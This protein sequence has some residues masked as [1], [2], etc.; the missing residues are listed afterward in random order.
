MSDHYDEFREDYYA[1][2]RRQEKQRIAR[3]VADGRIRVPQKVKVAM[4][5]IIKAHTVDPEALRAL[6]DFILAARS[7]EATKE[8]T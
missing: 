7:T 5:S 8:R 3:E 2:L 1:Y 4:E 6:A